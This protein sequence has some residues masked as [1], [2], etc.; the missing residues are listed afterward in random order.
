MNAAQRVAT[1]SGR[2]VARKPPPVKVPQFIRADHKQPLAVKRAPQLLKGPSESLK[3]Q[4]V[5]IA[6]RPWFYWEY[7]ADERQRLRT[8]ALVE[9]GY[10]AEHINLGRRMVSLNADLEECPDLAPLPSGWSSGPLMHP[11]DEV[12]LYTAACRIAATASE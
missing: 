8:E 1:I 9:E 7:P 6:E 4:L 12:L 5:T 2:L 3:E 11:E 10:L